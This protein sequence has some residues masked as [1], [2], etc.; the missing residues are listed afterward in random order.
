MPTSSEGQSRKALPCKGVLLLYAISGPKGRRSARS[1]SCK[2]EAC[3]GL[4][5]PH[6]RGG[7]AAIAR[8]H[9]PG[10]QTAGGPIA[11]SQLAAV[12]LHDGLCD[13]EPEADAAS[14][15]AAGFLHPVER[16][17]NAC[18]FRFGY[19]RPVIVDLD[20]DGSRPPCGSPRC[21]SCRT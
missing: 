6:F 4:P 16:L 3:I 1:A 21:P 5:V 7:L 14:L 10:A 18:K 15:A 17:Q 12:S 9:D 11:E 19:S 13:G 20:L 2:G 8:K